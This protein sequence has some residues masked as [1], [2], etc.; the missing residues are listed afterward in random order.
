[1]SLPFDAFH[2]AVPCTT[3]MTM[4]HFCFENIRLMN[5]LILINCYKHL[6]LYASD[7]RPDILLVT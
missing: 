4:E 6:V 7:V 5:Q 3:F 1:M 2:C